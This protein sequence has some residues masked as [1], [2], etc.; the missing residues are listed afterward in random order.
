MNITDHEKY[1]KNS[2]NYFN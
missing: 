2:M 1:K